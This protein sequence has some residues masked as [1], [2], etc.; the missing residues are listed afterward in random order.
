MLSYA[1]R[2]H[3]VA[4]PL[5]L[6]EVRGQRH[7]Q[8]RITITRRKI[9]SRL[10]DDEAVCGWSA[11]GW[12]LRTVVSLI[13]FGG[14]R[15][16]SGA[17]GATQT[18]WT[19][20]RA[21]WGPKWV[22]GLGVSVAFGLPSPPPP[23]SPALRFDSTAIAPVSCAIEDLHGGRASV[24]AA[25]G[26]GRQNSRALGEPI[27]THFARNRAFIGRPHNVNFRSEKQ[28]RLPS[29]RMGWL[30]CAH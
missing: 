19:M 29:F 13:R 6:R 5:V 14:H 12:S 7:E 28:T 25:M 26:R 4:R 8:E 11:S 2:R 23:T 21:G 15:R 9:G 24:R 27:A 30:P 17:N 3:S 16:G 20:A 18:D 1:R 22:C 10:R